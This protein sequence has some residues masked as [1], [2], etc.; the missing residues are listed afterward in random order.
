[1]SAKPDFD[2][3]T[4]HKYFAAHCFNSAWGLIDKKDRTPD[5][6]EAMVQLCQSSL[7][8]W[9]QRSD[10]TP[11]NLSVGYWQAARV[12]AIL[13]QNDNALHYGHLSLKAAQD[14]GPFYVGYAFEALARAALG[15]G[16]TAA[17]DD[18]LQKARE[19]ATAIS[20]AEERQMLEDDLKTIA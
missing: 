12:Y 6:D 19:Q 3:A 7:W 20:D 18:Y 4:A 11:T 13:G 10:C 16:D 15:A 14:A 9:N 8:H 5:E 2:L 1:M 17:R